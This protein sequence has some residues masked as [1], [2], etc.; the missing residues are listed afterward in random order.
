MQL[1]KVFQKVE[2]NQSSASYSIKINVDQVD[3]IV[4]NPNKIVIHIAIYEDQLIDV[5]E[6]TGKRCSSNQ[7]NYGSKTIG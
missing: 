3:M 2:I 6:V 7:K 4:Q 1:L 5:S